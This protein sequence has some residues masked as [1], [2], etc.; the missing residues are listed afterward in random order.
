LS[1]DAG[2]EGIE[3]DSGLALSG[4]WASRFLRVEVVGLDLL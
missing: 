3:A 2:F 4:A 1:V